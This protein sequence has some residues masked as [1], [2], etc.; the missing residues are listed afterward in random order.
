MFE[1]MA[2]PSAAKEVEE[3]E[4]IDLTA[5]D[6]KDYSKKLENGLLTSEQTLKI[7]KLPSSSTSEFK[8]GKQQTF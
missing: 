2:N 7:A 8:M 1:S 6:L 3:E 5:Q 4:E